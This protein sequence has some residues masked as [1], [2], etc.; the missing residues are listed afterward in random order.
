MGLLVRSATASVG[1]F[2]VAGGAAGLTVQEAV[3]ADADVGCGLAEAAELIAHALVFRHFAL[4][5]TVFGVAGSGGHS[6]NL[7][8][9]GDAW[10]ITE[11]MSGEGKRVCGVA[12]SLSPLRRFVARR[13]VRHGLRRL[14]GLMI[15]VGCILSLRRRYARG[16]RAI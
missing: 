12:S 5:A 11:V 7:A 16:L 3:G 9:S 4:G 10:N 2:V 1:G 8:L 15:T 13:S 6:N 14:G